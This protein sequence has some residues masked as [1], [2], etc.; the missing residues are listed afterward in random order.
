MI[1]FIM[2][3]LKSSESR[4][5]TISFIVISNL[6]HYNRTACA[7]FFTANGPESY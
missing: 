1:Y 6:S 2:V 4:F 7:I 3:I 5:K